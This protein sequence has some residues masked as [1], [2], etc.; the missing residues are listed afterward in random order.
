MSTR[1][2]TQQGDMLDL[3]CLR[4]YG[5]HAGTA[6]AVLAANP[7]LAWQGPVYPAGIEILLPDLPQVKSAPGRT[8]WS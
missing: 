8:L 2:R 7:G 4:R 6:E 5:R 1:Y 3:I